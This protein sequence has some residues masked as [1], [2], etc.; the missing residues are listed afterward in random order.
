MGNRFQT[1]VD[2]STMAVIIIDAN[3]CIEYINEASFDVMKKHKKALLSVYPQFNINSLVG[4]KI[5]DIKPVSGNFIEYLKDPKRK[6]I[7]KFIDIGHE[8]IHV[9]ITPIIDDEKDT[10][11]SIEWW[12]AT[13]YLKGQEH[14]KN[15][16]EITRLI[17][18]LTFQTNILAI[19]AAVEA[20]HA[21]EEGKSFAVIASEMRSLSQRC[22]N[23]IKEIHDRI[24]EVA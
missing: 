18:D 4:T 14:N 20:A 5:R 1:V 7:S 13:D 2:G 9:S 11:T 22:R 21:G 10:G 3:L 24:K 16:T 8:K 12:Y 6:T 15:I 17:D 19:N 23:A